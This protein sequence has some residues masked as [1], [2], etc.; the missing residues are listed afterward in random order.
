MSSVDGKILL[1]RRR[2]CISIRLWDKLLR[3]AIAL[4][5][6]VAEKGP[7]PAVFNNAREYLKKRHADYRG[8]NAYWMETLIEQVRYNSDDMLTNNEVLESVTPKNVQRIARRLIRSRHT[9]EVIM[10]GRN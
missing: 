8:T 4:L 10:N 5:A 2:A 7:S 9:A 1:T 3:Q 6:Q